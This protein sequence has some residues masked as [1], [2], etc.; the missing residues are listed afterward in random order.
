[1]ISDFFLQV[2]ICSPL[3]ITMLVVADFPVDFINTVARSG[4]I[5][6]YSVFMAFGL[7]LIFANGIFVWALL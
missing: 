6:T 7:F 4:T 1:M 2:D 3:G 5:I